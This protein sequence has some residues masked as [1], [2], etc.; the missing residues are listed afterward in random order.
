MTTKDDYFKTG[1][2]AEQFGTSEFE[3]RR[4]LSEE[5][6]RRYREEYGYLRAYFKARPNKY[7]A[8]Q[9]WLN[10]ARVATTYDK[11][12][13]QSVVYGLILGIFGALLGG[14]LTYQLSYMGFLSSLQN[15]FPVG[16]GV[17]P[18]VGAHRLFF[19]GVLMVLLGGGLFGVATWNVRYYAPYV[20]STMRRQEINV[21]MPH[22]VVFMYA[23]SHGGTSLFETFT[24]LADS[25]DTYG[26][27]SKEFEMVVNDVE[28]FGTDMH[29]AIRHARKTTP[30]KPLKRF[31]DDLL[32][33]L[34]SGG[35]V[36]VMLEEETD[37][38]LREAREE[39]EN[40]LETISL[41]AEVFV[42]LFVAAPL[43]LIVTLVVI[44]MAG[45]NSLQP[46]SLLVYIVMPLAMGGFIF[47]IDLLGRP[48]ELPQATS[49]LPAA[50]ATR[51]STA[52]EDSERFEDYRWNRRKETLREM[53]MNPRSVLRMNPLYSVVISVPVALALVA[54]LIATGQVT[55]SL[56]AIQATPVW[57]TTAL[58]LAPF[59][60][61][62]VPL[63]LFHDLKR[64]HEQVIAHEFP[65]TLTVLASANKMGVSFTDALELISEW[66]GDVIGEELR[67]VRNDIVWNYDVRRALIAFGNRVSV[68]QLGRTMK[69]ISEGIYRSGDISKVL[70]IAAADIRDRDELERARRRELSTYI[71][72]VVIGFLVYLM[73]IV[74]LDVGYLQAIA[75]FSEEGTAESGTLITGFRDVPVQTYQTIFL[76]SALIQAVGTGLLAGKLADNDTL[77]GLK[78]GIGLALVTMA[79][80]V[81]I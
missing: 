46:V 39:Q 56:D 75:E 6:Y 60:V 62:A 3:I 4:P 73:A 63:A 81:L 64:R 27:V 50:E 16:L 67:R 32:G 51:D 36:T 7:T 38:Y 44:D 61:V 20:R 76:H 41:L 42:V 19:A 74:L 25:Q 15:P 8:I 34:E 1:G 43:F 33:I 55:P 17:A 65:K 29:S 80:F 66:S 40:F 59:L 14:L 13:A 28:L 9:Q 58:F 23:L 12:L 78:Y 54:T 68:P 18:F 22:A 45:G 79:V 11:Y 72:V 52:I 21:L 70:S 53:V 10:Q 49:E 71:A 2:P 24:S 31:F 69:L 48:F 26:E 30:S 47:L 77:S 5:E 37:T 57:S 35:D